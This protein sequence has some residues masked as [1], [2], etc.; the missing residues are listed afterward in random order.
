MGSKTS[1]SRLDVSGQRFGKL[2]AIKPAYSKPGRGVYWECQCDCGNTVVKALSSLKEGYSKTCGCYRKQFDLTGQQFGRVLVLHIDQEKTSDRYG[3][4][5][6]CRCDCGREFTTKID[7]LRSGNTKSCGCLKSKYQLPEKPLQGLTSHRLS[8][9]PLYGVHS[10]MLGR[11]FNPKDQSFKYY[12]GRGITVC[13]EWK[14]SFRAFFDWSMANGYRKG[15][16][17]DRHNNHGNYEPS[18][19]RWTTQLVNNR[20][21]RRMKRKP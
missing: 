19:C 5:W 18:N 12:G 16:C 11:C 14:E 15:L 13:K 10:A 2:V 3:V 7:Y 1:G 20:N 6:R 8:H 4:W 9:H 17:I 21:M